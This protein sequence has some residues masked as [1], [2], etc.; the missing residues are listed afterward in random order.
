[1]TYQFIQP[2]PYLR[3]FVSNY[4][5]LHLVFDSA[6]PIP[7]KPFPVRPEQCIVFYLRGRITCCNPQTGH[8]VVF[9]KVAINGPQ[10]TR[11]D[12]RL[13]PDYLMF[14]VDFQPG[15]L[16]KFLKIPFNDDFIDDR[17]DAEAILNPGIRE[18]HERMANASRYEQLV[19][20]IEGYL[21]QRIQQLRP[22]YQ[23]ID[24]VCQLI[25]N[26]PAVFSMEQL[27]DKACLS[28]S[29]FERRFT[30]QVGLPP[31]LFARINRYY[32]AFMLKD[33]NPDLDWLSI[34]LQTGYTDYQHL[35]KDVKQFSGATP[36]SLLLAQACAPERI[37]GIG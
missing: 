25:A 13:T 9:P 22:G 37:L 5:L 12:F 29:Q 4:F 16:S 31:K 19:P 7:V 27:A 28:L 17:I 18:L 1:M 23:G 10:L 2:S 8:S 33:Q 14:S 3:G 26:Q 20:I 6:K 24:H 36:N 32:R 30:R 15:M 34:A 35:V 21:W 11:F